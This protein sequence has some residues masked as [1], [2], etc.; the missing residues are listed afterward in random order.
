MKITD[1][2]GKKIEV[3]NLDLALI[4]ADDFRHYRVSVPTA[5]HERL[6]VYWEDIYQKLLTLKETEK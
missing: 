2:D 3:E 4:Q 6:Y 5:M 1:L